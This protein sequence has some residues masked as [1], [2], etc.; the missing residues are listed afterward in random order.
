MGIK[1]DGKTDPVTLQTIADKLGVSRTTVSNAFSKPDQ[2]TPKLRTKI[3]K[4]ADELGYCGPDPAARSLRKG[5]SGA[6]GLI[7]NESLSYT[8]ADPAAVLLLQGIAEVFDQRSAGLLI[9]PSYGD[10][11][12]GVQ[13]VL[14]AVVDG[15]IVY[16][17]ADDDPRITPVVARKAPMVVIEEPILEGVALVGLDDRDGARQAAAHVIALGHRNLG[18]LTFPLAEDGR[19]GFVDD[20]RMEQAKLR[21]SRERLSGFAEAAEANGI[22]WDAV[23]IFET[24]INT[25]EEA[26]RGAGAILDRAD[27]PTAILATSDVLAMGAMQAIRERGLDVPRDI[28]VTGFDDIPDA[29]RSDPPLTTVRQPLFEKGR[30]SAQ[31]LLD[32][33]EGE[34]PKQILA[35]ELVVRASTGPAPATNGH[36]QS[37]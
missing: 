13:P 29:A 33:W 20:T 6:Y 9:I 35:L 5:K 34:P 19:T 8:V 28:S 22:D 24:V 10:R 2:L 4:I 1:H 18:V 26:K 31:M 30:L 25:I 14:D 16:S 36:R 7:L 21:I 32:G 15:F 37:F 11:T 3:F 17:L 12:L 27:R 23:P